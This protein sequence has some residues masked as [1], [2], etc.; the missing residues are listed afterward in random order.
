MALMP[1]G[2]RT[3]VEAR[4]AQLALR[5]AIQRIWRAVMPRAREERFRQ[6]TGVDPASVDWLVLG[7]LRPKGYILLA[8]GPFDADLVVREAGARLAALETVVDEPVLRREGVSGDARYAYAVVD[9]HTVMV[10]RDAPAPLLAQ[11][12]A[13]LGGDQDVPGV[14]DEPDARSLYADRGAHPL[15]IYAPQP[16]RL[17]VD[18]GVGVLL[19]R[20]RALAARFEPG[21][22]EIDVELE[23]RGEFPPGAE[24]NFRAL[25]KSLGG[26][27]LGAV[28][29]L[30]DIGDA[31]RIRADDQGVELQFP[32]R[33][34]ALLRGVRMLFS[35]DLMRMLQ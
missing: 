11:F 13:R 8:R 21:D 20:E 14:M 34:Q 4:P 26:T 17:P 24:Q 19:S 23:L 3:V 32:L 33:T 18:S 1:A 35:Q 25:V 9:F 6:R 31:L 27:D 12:V 29:G 2:P 22:V 15:A 5:P 30:A 28:L 16:L 10:A 7:E